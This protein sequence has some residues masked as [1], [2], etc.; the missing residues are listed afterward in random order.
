MCCSRLILFRFSPT[1]RDG[2]ELVEAEDQDAVLIKVRVL[3]CERF[4]RV[5]RDAAA[6]AWRDGRRSIPQQ[7]NSKSRR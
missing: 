1:A 7:C 4:G 2:L 5:D 3:E 6:E